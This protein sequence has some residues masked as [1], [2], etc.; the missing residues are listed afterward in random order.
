LSQSRF[1][2][3]RVVALLN[4]CVH[5]FLDPLALLEHFGLISLLSVL[6][7]DHVG[8]FTGLG[9][10]R[11]TVNDVPLVLVGDLGSIIGHFVIDHFGRLGFQ[12]VFRVRSHQ[13]ALAVLAMQINHVQLVINL[14]KLSAVD[15]VRVLVH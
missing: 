2:D 14:V 7:L 11:Q 10:Q 8:V 1:H 9:E 15:D 3:V 5:L 13:H 6:K 12:V 4:C